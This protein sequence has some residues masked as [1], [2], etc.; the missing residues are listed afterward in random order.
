MKIKLSLF[1]SFFIM[2][3]LSAQEYIVK[4]QKEGSKKFSY[5]TINGESQ[6]ETAYFDAT[7]FGEEGIAIAKITVS[8]FYQIYDKKGEIINSEAIIKPIINE[9]SSIASGF[10]DGMVI[11][12][13]NE[14]YGAVNYEGK[15]SVPGVYT[16]LTEFNGN[17]AIGTKG[18]VYFVVN[19][20]GEEI[21]LDIPKIR[22]AKHF[23]EGL[24]PIKIKGAYG[25]ID[26]LGQ[27][28]I[29]PKYKSTGHFNGGVAW[30]KNLDGRVGYIDKSG[31][32]LVEP[33]F[34]IGDDYDPESGYARVKSTRGWAYIDTANQFTNLGV[35]NDYFNF[36][37]G[38]AINR[39][40]GRIGFID[41]TGEW[42]IKPYFAVAHKFTNGFA[43]V[44][45]NGKWGLIDKKGEW[46]VE[47][48]YK[49]I[50]NAIL[51]KE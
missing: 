15:L 41:H 40:N 14:N 35:T 30:A 43:R 21:K 44:Q 50:G 23:S 34:I 31:K 22:A 13:I 32:W 3:S 45:V 38:L 11:T 2:Y 16:K 37:E 48:N 5:L 49:E 27:V 47:P 42:V 12:K 4:V 39:E 9:W 19:N 25:Y 6:I 29:R 26:T 24:A 28:V 17:H 7:D 33:I 1:L 18:R 51:I 10:I 20:K 8:S 36:S 46:L